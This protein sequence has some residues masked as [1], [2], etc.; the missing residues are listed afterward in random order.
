[1]RS[2]EIL[3]LVK[4]LE[5]HDINEIEVSRWGRK[6]RIAKT[7][8]SYVESEPAIEVTHKSSK[9]TQHN[10]VIENLVFESK[11]A[12]S[13]EVD[14]KGVEIKAPIVGTFYRAPAPDA[15]PYVRV[16][17]MVSVGQP[18]CIIE[19]MKIMNVIESEVAG[20]VLQILVENAQPVEFNQTLFIIEKT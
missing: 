18:L 8:H 12:V 17:D 16:G 10:P 2:K 14:H 6:I 15:E 5:S 9:P 4:I 13:E 1:M 20:K 3:E 11:P 19:A 7:T